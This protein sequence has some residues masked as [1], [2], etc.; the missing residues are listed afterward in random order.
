MHIRLEIIRRYARQSVERCFHARLA[1][2]PVPALEIAR[3]GRL[4]YAVPAND[5]ATLPALAN[6]I[7]CARAHF[8]SG[9]PVDLVVA[10]ATHPCSEGVL[11][12]FTEACYRIRTLIGTTQRQRLEHR[13]VLEQVGSELAA[14][15]RQVVKRVEV[16]QAS[17]LRHN[18]VA[19]QSS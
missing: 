9:K 18:R 11:K 4:G 15:S 13:P 8:A 2:P 1:K 14:C 19:A 16:E 10:P 5:L 17:Q 6:H 3:M 7:T 12:S